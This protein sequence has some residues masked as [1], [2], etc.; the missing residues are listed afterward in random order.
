MVTHFTDECMHN[1][2]GYP[3]HWQ[4]WFHSSI[5]G[6]MATD[7]FSNLGDSWRQLFS[8]V[9]HDTGTVAKYHYYIENTSKRLFHDSNKDNMIRDLERVMELLFNWRNAY[10]YK[11]KHNFDT[12][13]ETEMPFDEIFATGYTERCHFEHFQCS[14]RLNFVKMTTHYSDVTISAMA[15]QSPCGSIVCS[16]VCSGKDQRKHQSSAS[17][18]TRKIFSFDDVIMIFFM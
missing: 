3:S 14:Q 4:R 17:V 2:N 12:Y 1:Y 7:S 8:A 5:A 16:T 6:T 15:S 11:Y 18:V 9:K 10:T 13:T